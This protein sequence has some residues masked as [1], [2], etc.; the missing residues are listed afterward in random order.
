MGT[1]LRTSYSPVL[2]CQCPGAREEPPVGGGVRWGFY[3]GRP[4]R[5]DCHLHWSD[6]SRSR[7][8]V[9]RLNTTS[10]AHANPRPRNF[11]DVTSVMVPKYPGSGPRVCYQR[12]PK[13]ASVLR[14]TAAHRSARSAPRTSAIARIVTGTRYD[15][16]GRPRYGVGVRYGAS[17]STSTRSSGAISSASRSGWAFLN[18]TVPANDS[19]APRSRQRRATWA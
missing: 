8:S 19:Q 16:F 5:C 3:A 9:T 6:R 15:A 4:L 14:S 1:I 18:V 10:G 2:G 11:T 17:V 7:P 12:P 13:A